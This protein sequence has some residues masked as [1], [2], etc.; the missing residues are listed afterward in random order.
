MLMMMNVLC[1]CERWWTKVISNNDDDL[2]LNYFHKIK[3]LHERKNLQFNYCWLPEMMKAQTDETNWKNCS[4]H[5]YTS[6]S[7]ER[8]SRELWV[9]RTSHQ[10]SLLPPITLHQ[11]TNI[12]LLFQINREMVNTIWFRFGLRRFR[13]DKKLCHE[14]RMFFLRLLI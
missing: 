3:I 13:K 6:A 2:L 9:L 4:D 11:Q 5:M 12:R 7:R 10:T 1:I 8:I 14:P